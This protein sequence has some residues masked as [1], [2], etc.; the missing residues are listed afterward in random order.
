MKYNLLVNCQIE[1]KTI[2]YRNRAFQLK[3]LLGSGSEGAAYLATAYNWG[4]NPQ[5]VVIKLQKNMKPNER[6]FLT[7]LIQY[8]TQFENG[9]NQQY[10]PSHLI[11]IYEYFEWRENHCIIM[12]VGKESLYDYINLNKNVSMEQRVKICYQICQPIYFLHSY[13]LI[14]RDI[15][16]ESYIKVGEIFKLIDFG[17]IRSSTSDYK[18]Q[19]VGSAIFQAPEILENSSSYTEKVDIWSLAC[20]FYEILST[21]PL[22]DGSSIQQVIA[23]IKN[24]KSQ[25]HIKNNKIKNLQISSEIKE[26]LIKMLEY[27]ENARPSIEWVYQQLQQSIKNKQISE[28]DFN[29]IKSEKIQNLEKLQSSQI[30]FDQGQS[31]ITECNA[32]FEKLIM[33]G[34][35]QFINI[36]NN[37]NKEY[38][39]NIDKLKINYQNEMI[40][41]LEEL[42]KQSTNEKNKLEQDQQQLKSEFQQFQQKSKQEEAKYQKEINQLKNE[43]KEFDQQLNQA[44]LYLEKH[45][46]E[47]KN[48]QYELKELQIKNQN[49]EII[50]QELQVKLKETR[51]PL[52]QSKS[53]MEYIQN[54]QN[55]QMIQIQEQGFS[56]KTENKS[57]DCLNL[58]QN[59][60][61][62][63]YERQTNLESNQ[64][65]IIQAN[66][67]QELT[68]ELQESNEKNV[69]IENINKDLTKQLQESQQQFKE[70]KQ[71]S[72]KENERLKSELENLQKKTQEQNVRQSKEIDQLNK[73]I[74]EVQETLQNQLNQANKPLN[75]VKGLIVYFK[76]KEN[77]SKFSEQNNDLF[78]ELLESINQQC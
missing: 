14:H 52:Y 63:D 33:K 15:K 60:N 8:Q 44:N 45:K 29:S 32:V 36:L 56:E 10:L 7:K 54:L 72:I 40:K 70:F 71:I 73:R 30:P 49:Y 65:N 38:Q 48:I 47:N 11:T 66:S 78:M 58:S 6:D 61:L 74:K 64:K 41:Q 16:P 12:E 37:Q 24:H 46:Q 28:F 67:N 76:E 31:A 68:I 69:K 39:S 62:I 23:S 9:N 51:N 13:K 19:Q 1:A 59:V 25:P 5:Q 22:F 2:D 43:L 50:I 17:L 35:K 42:R 3:Q 4:N 53:L 57:R 34:Q 18:T 20:V 27:Q 26:I 75:Q 77:L 55:V 21:Q